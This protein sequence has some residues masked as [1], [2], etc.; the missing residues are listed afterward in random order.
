MRADHILWFLFGVL[1]AWLAWL[2]LG[3]WAPP[4]PSVER[5]CTTYLDGDGVPRRRWLT[6]DEFYRQRAANGWTSLC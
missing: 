6:W 3:I 4:S 1:G 5:V 2:I